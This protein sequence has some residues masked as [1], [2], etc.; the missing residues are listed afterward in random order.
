MFRGI[1]FRQY[2]PSMDL[3]RIIKSFVFIKA[4]PTLKK[5]NILPVTAGCIEIYFN[6]NDTESRCFDQSEERLLK[7]SMVVGIEPL[8]HSR[9]IQL[10]NNYEC[11]VVVFKPGSFYHVFGIAERELIGKIYSLPLFGNSSLQYLAEM[12]DATNTDQV[13]INVFE[14]FVRMKL[15]NTIKYV[16]NGYFDASVNDNETTVYNQCKKNGV[17]I[18]TLERH[19]M[20]VLGLS[21][22]Q[23]IRIARINQCFQQLHLHKQMGWSAFAALLGYYDQA[24]FIKDFKAI[25]HLTPAEFVAKVPDYMYNQKSANR[26]FLPITGP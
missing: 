6:L 9:T 13:R 19:Y 12:I 17:S 14:T 26:T 7:G 4:T 20:E 23:Y 2:S 11:F 3:E 25:T 22:C 5:V 1:D 16:L 24:H 21:P 18:R 10:C 8:N 15:R